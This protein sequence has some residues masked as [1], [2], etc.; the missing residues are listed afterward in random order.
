MNTDAL[1]DLNTIVDRYLFKFKLPTEDAF[2]YLEHCA[3]CVRDFHLYDSPNVVPAKVTISALGIIEMP[4]DMVGF[5]DLYKFVDGKKW[6]FTYRDDMITTT[7]VTGGIEGQ[8]ASYGEGEALVDPKS[9]T[10]GGVGGVNDY[11]YKPDWKERRIFCEGTINDTAVLEYITSGIEVAGTTYVP[12][13]ITPMLDNYMLWKS[14]YWIPTLIR[15]RESLEKDY[16]KSELKIRNL[17]NSM[18]Y[19]EWHDLLL[20]LTTLVPQR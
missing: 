8:D 18:S 15:E 10:Y 4:S 2:I 14:S 6:P 16:T 3:N 20:S 5:N 11:Y 9:D 13:F 12:E 1:L 7:T 19:S 17:I